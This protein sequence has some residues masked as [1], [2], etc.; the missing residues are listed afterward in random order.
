MSDEG[1]LFLSVTRDCLLSCEDAALLLA[2]L[3]RVSFEDTDSAASAARAVARGLEK[4][5]VHTLAHNE[6][7][8][9]QAVLLRLAASRPEAESLTTLHDALT[10][11]YG[12]LG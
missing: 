4:G 3:E 7:A 10:L 8:A 11:D 6:V 9:V 1:V 2:E 5:E 12:E